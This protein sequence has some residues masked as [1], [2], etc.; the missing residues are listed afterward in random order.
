MAGFG[1]KGCRGMPK[2]RYIEKQLGVRKLAV[3][4]QA[5]AI[6]EEYAGQGFTLTLRQLYYQF[7]ARALIANTQRNYKCLGDAL[8]DGRLC[9]LIDWRSIVDRTRNLQALSHWSDPAAIVEACGE[10][11]NL[12]RWANQ[13]TYVEVWIEKDALI[14]VIAD[15]CERLDVPYFS[16]RGY[17]S[18]SELWSAAMR[19]GAL[20]DG[21]KRVVVLHFG[22]HDPSGM[23]MTR[24]IQARFDLFVD[25]DTSRVE[26]RRLA[27]T[28]A[29]IE[30]Y[31]PPPNPAKVTDSRFERYAAE[32][33]DDSWE[34]D[35]LEPAVIAALI[36]EHVDALRDQAQWDEDTEQQDDYREEIAA[37]A[38]RWQTAVEAVRGS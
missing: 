11:F 34:L 38:A 36:E 12:D 4:E 35:A 3:I 21:E 28:Y 23:D 32:F 16:C 17:T 6:I 26:V 33:G 30:T 37:V 2:I 19:L 10:Q 27:L 24:D 25:T 31:A 14:G 9:G 15:V 1:L 22:D 7:V 20:S 13:E 8:N 5:N 18:Q 29:Q